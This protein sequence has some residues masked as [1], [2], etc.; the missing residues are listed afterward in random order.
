MS[1]RKANNPLKRKQ[2]IAR[3]ILKDLAVVM[4]LVPWRLTLKESLAL[5]CKSRC[6]LDLFVPFSLAVW[7]PS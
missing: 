6:T 5:H 4:V 1:K 3:K 2:Q 7:S